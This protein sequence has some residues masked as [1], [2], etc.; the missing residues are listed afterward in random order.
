L[1]SNESSRQ[2]LREGEIDTF[3]LDRRVALNG[4]PLMQVEYAITANSNDQELSVQIG[5]SKSLR[6]AKMT[7]AFREDYRE[8]L[9]KLSCPPKESSIAERS[10]ASPDQ[11]QERFTSVSVKLHPLDW[12]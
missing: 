3:L 4:V 8:S 9:H 2:E 1:L 7:S 12:F 10:I 6:S 5:R 11:Y